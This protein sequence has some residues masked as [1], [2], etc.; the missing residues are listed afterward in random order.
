MLS[1]IF[2]S[3][4]SI[5]ILTSRFLKKLDGCIA[6]SFRKNRRSQNEDN[7]EDLHDQMRKVKSKTDEESKSKLQRVTEKIAE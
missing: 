5:D 7:G 4:E 6:R 2:D 1:S 3:K